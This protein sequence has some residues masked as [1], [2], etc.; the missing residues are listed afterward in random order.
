M[1]IKVEIDLPNDYC[2]PT[3]LFEIVKT[4]FSDTLPEIEG[5]YLLEEDKIFI[6]YDTAK[7]IFDFSGKLVIRNKAKGFLTYCI[8]FIIT[9]YKGTITDIYEYR[10]VSEE[11]KGILWKLI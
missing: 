4:D 9:F 10:K 8:D 1:Q 11:V 3:N 2:F 7:L 5:T 6:V